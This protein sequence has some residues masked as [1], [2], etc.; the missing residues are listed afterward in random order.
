[1]LI[2]RIS[3]PFNAEVISGVSDHLEGHGYLVSIL[4]SRD[5]VQHKGRNLKR[6]FAVRVV[7]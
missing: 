3:N 7:D 4:D 6:L 2:H 5:D 1:M